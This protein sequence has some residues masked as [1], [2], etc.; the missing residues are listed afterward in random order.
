M[1]LSFQKAAVLGST[2]PT[3]KHLVREL[4]DRGL[5]VRV[6]SRSEANLSRAFEGLQV[7]RRAADLLDG[8]PTL[9]SVEGCDLVF[10]CIG[11]P[12]DRIAGHPVAAR[13]IAL[14][15]KETGA[16]CV[17]VSSFWAYLPLRH[18]PLSENH[19]REGGPLAVRMRREA[20]DILQSAGAAVV[21][22]P[23]FYG[24]EVHT[25]ML[26]Q[27][28]QEAV[29]GKPVN[30]IGSADTAREHV[31]VPDAMKTV[32]E[33]AQRPEAYGE[34][35]V[36]P[37]AGPLTL[38]QTAAIIKSH[39]GAE[40]RARTA[41]PLMLRLVSLFSS[42]LRGLMPL[43]PD[44][45]KPLTYDGGKLTKLLGQVAATPYEQGIPLTLDWIKKQQGSG[46]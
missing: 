45:V 10:D 6:V 26:Q 23:D 7:E 21:N 31:Y 40:I 34:R 27:A 16:R 22:L 30:W 9:R 32:A 42:E 39:L 29:A 1:T 37:A 15:V 17:H 44:Y 13:N 19:P 3:G 24:P 35:W 2:G 20:E 33:L 11:L 5:P 4:L 14:A 46:K 28:L 38:T 43:V 18:V 12:L 41:G 8:A 25:S 36:V